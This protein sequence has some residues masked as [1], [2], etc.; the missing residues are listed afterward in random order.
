[1]TAPAETPLPPAYQTLLQ[2]LQTR[3]SCRA[4]LPQP[5][6]RSTIERILEAAQR[7]ASWCNAQPWQL[8]IVSGDALER[9]RTAL[10]AHVAQAPPAPDLPWPSEYRG[11]YLQRR[12]ECG[13]G[14]YQA[15]GIAKD[16][17]AASQRQAAQNYTMFGAPHVAIVTSDAALGVYGAVDCGAYV[18]NFMLAAH[19]LGVGSIAQAALAAYPQVLRAELDIGTDRTI[20]CGISFGL[21]DAQHPANRFRTNRAPFSDCVVWRD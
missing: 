8:T 13:W 18:A 2:L 17:R 10:L 19:S 6:P 16:D 5:L 20:V 14:L 4:F 7:T 12:R 21:A 3:Y 11:V 9:L 15:L 1:M